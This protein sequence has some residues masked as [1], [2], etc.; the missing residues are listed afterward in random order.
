MP[1]Y[2][3][4]CESCRLR[5]E[6]LQSVADEPLSV[7]AECGGTLK[8]LISAPGIQ[9]KGSGWYV[10]D[11]SRKGTAP[12]GSSAEPAAESKTE[13][14]PETK[15]GSSGSGAAEKKGE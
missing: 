5:T 6:V 2:E 12:A 1:L 10:S 3:Y 8:R 7:C 11:Y 15:A 14:K 13:A 4:E 9:F